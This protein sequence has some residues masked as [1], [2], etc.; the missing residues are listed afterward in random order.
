MY[1][2]F[3]AGLGAGGG[4]EYAG[5]SMVRWL[6]SGFFLLAER[7]WD[8]AF[9]NNLGYDLVV[10]WEGLEFCRDCVVV[11]CRLADAFMFALLVILSRS[12][13]E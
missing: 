11:H 8:T 5:K 9:S 2:E 12:C 3:V 10:R 7:E 4:V 1:V 6:V 13:S